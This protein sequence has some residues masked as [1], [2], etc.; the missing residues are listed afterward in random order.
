[1]IPGI[2][3]ESAVQGLDEMLDCAPYNKLFWRGDCHFIEESTGSLEF[4][5]SV[6]AEVL[7]KRI[8]R[9]LLTE[10]AAKDIALKIFRDNAI[11]FFK[12]DEI[13]NKRD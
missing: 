6:V 8:D 12:L 1:M 3:R 13:P 11:Q 9:G 10:D 7:T 4:G 5:K 2:S